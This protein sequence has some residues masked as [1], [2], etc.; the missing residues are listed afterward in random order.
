MKQLARRYIY[1]TETDKAIEW[2]VKSCKLKVG[3]TWFNLGLY[4]YWL[5]WLVWKRFLLNLR[6]CKVKMGRSE[7]SISCTN[8]LKHNWPFKYNCR[9]LWLPVL[10]LN[11]ASI[12]TSSGLKQCCTFHGIFQ[13]LIVPGHT[14]TNDLTEENVQILKSSSC[15][16]SR[17][18]ATLSL[19]SLWCG[20]FPAE[21]Y[22]EFN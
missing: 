3:R 15:Q 19:N 5:C 6:G 14:V 18:I 10:V 9:E 16:D 20:Q 7:S 13:K 1:W 2:T 8:H 4:T 17:N 22:F 12:F 11:N 21:S